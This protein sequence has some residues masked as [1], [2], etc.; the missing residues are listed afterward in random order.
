[1]LADVDAEVAELEVAVG[2]ECVWSLQRVRFELQPNGR[3]RRRD[4]LGGE[5]QDHLFR[6]LLSFQAFLD[7]RG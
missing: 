6:T 5:Q 7:W 2:F 4:G 3:D 1:M